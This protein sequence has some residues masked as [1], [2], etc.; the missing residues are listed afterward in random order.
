MKPTTTCF[1]FGPAYLPRKRRI[2]LAHTLMDDLEKLILE[3]N[4]CAFRLC[5]SGSFSLVAGYTVLNLKEKY[6][7]ICLFFDFPVPPGPR[8]FLG[9]NARS[10]SA[11]LL[12]CD[13][14]RALSPLPFWGM[15]K[16][17]MCAALSQCDF[18][19]SYESFALFYPRRRFLERMCQK[20]CFLRFPSKTT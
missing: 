4:C 18:C 7:D 3:E 13:Y 16:A 2:H 9:G 20:L 12:S 15:K 8:R 6:P 14:Y 1:L 10:L 19:M 11:L 5:D 17:A